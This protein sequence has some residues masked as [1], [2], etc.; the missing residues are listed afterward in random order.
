MRLLLVVLAALA[1]AGH[2]FAWT[3]DA[4]ALARMQDGRPYVEVAPGADGASGRIRAGIDVEAPRDVVWRVIT[5]C[6]LAPRMVASLRS[7]KVLEK[8]PGGRWDVREHV[9]RPRMLPAVR[10]VFRSDYDPPG[11]IVFRKAGGELKM[12]NGE[13]RLEPLRGGAATRVLYEQNAA[14]PYRV[15]GMVIRMGM[16]RDVPQALLALRRVAEARAGT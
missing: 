2:A 1:A 13:W 5:D 8:D 14:F 12:L 15:P 16:R 11:R 9:S 7:C 4:P 10:S 6:A 3:P